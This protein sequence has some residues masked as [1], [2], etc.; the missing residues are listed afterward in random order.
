MSL[1]TVLLHGISNWCRKNKINLNVPKC[2]I[3]NFT[4]KRSSLLKKHILNSIE[5]NRVNHIKY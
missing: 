5:L 4:K 3:I 2:K 1:D